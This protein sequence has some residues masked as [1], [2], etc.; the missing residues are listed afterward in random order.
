MQLTKE[1]AIKEHRKM[2]NWIADQ[3]E[4]HTDLIEKYKNVDSLKHY[5]VN[6][7]FP[8]EDI[9][10][11]CFCCEYDNQYRELD[12]L[13]NDC[14]H[15]PLKWGSDRDVDMCLYK[16]SEEYNLYGVLHEMQY[17]DYLSFDFVLCADLARQIANLPERK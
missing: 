16:N 7:Y 9:E 6:K 10:C 5:Y 2:W 12:I 13:L 17:E 4:Q 1:Q 3:Y 15:C 14:Y 11:N 8:D